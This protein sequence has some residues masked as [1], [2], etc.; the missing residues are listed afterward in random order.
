MINF[1]SEC[2]VRVTARATRC[3]RCS[4][5]AFNRETKRKY[6]PGF[7]TKSSLYKIWR[8]MHM[9]CYS[10]AH[11][12]FKNYGG[13]GITI[14]AA[15]HDYAAFMD[16]ARG[17]GFCD[18]LTIERKDND[19]D[20]EPNNC[21]WIERPRQQAHKRASLPPVTAFGETK[22]IADWSRDARCVVSYKLLWRRIAAGKP[23]EL[24]ITSPYRTLDDRSGV[25]MSDQQRHRLAELRRSNPMARDPGTG[26]FLRDRD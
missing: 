17:S 16:W 25:V 19:K 5:T 15:W 24:A 23:A 13:R 12:G 11:S 7:D 26:H 8:G 20:Y 14:T 3:K 18:G 1:C 6:P 9:R 21:T 4:T 10:P 22:S 2:G